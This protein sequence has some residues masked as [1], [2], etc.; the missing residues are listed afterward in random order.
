MKDTAI[1]ILL[2]A[3]TVLSLG[4]AAQKTTKAIQYYQVTVYNFSNTEQQKT[5]N[6]YLQNA[7]LPALHTRHISNIGVFTPLSNDTATSKQLYVI[8]P[9][10]SFDQAATLADKIKTDQQYLANGKTYLEAA[11]NN[12]PY[13]RME[14]ILLEKFSMAP[15]LTLPKL[16]SAKAERIYELRSYESATEKIFSN[17]VEMFNEGKEIKIFEKLQFNPVFYAKVIAGSRMP[18]L[19]YMTSF[20]NMNE[21]EEHWKKFGADVD[22]KR[23]SSMPHYQNN[24]SKA[25]I[26]LMK[27]TDYSDY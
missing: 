24:V 9:L 4:A 21:R 1:K 11:Y 10:K 26:I 19:M 17:K 13:Q 7:Y 12:P 15:F 22:W 27:A 18:N 14:N 2:F 6:D 25:D 16:K 3:C 20:E 8:F 5:I 23:I